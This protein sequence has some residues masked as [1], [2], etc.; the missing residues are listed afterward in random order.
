MSELEK[1]SLSD[2]LADVE[3]GFEGEEGLGVNSHTT[4]ASAVAGGSAATVQ[5][6]DID[7]DVFEFKEDR[8]DFREMQA[9]GASKKLMEASLRVIRSVSKPLLQGGE[10]IRIECIHFSELL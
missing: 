10:R 8:L 4:P 5:H 6:D 7:D 9:L 2:A 3:E 1:L